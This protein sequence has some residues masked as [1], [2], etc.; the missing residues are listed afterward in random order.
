MHVE[1]EE[2]SALDDDLEI[3]APHRAHVAPQP[4]GAPEQ[5]ALGHRG[6]PFEH[7]Q[8]VHA[9][10][11]CVN[12]H[13][14]ARR[15]EHR[16]GEVHRDA[17][18]SRDRSRGN[19]PRPAYDRRHTDPALPGRELPVEVRAVV[20]E[21]LTTVVV[22]EDDDGVAR[23]AEPVERGENLADALVHALHERH[24]VGA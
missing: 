10:E 24:V 12:G 7:G 6:A 11:A 1:Q 2:M 21:P 5:R 8:E 15:G 23:E 17:H 14:H 22:R 9:L 3:T 20:G 13:G 16:R 4:R 19:A 18:L